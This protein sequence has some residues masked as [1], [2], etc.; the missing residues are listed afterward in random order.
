MNQQML[1]ENGTLW[2]IILIAVAVIG[3]IALWS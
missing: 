2:L 1:C 3:L